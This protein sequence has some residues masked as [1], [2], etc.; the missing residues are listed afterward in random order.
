MR[1]NQA[2]LKF[3]GILAF[4]AACFFALL[5]WPMVS[6]I[7]QVQAEIVQAEAD[8]GLT[9]GRTDGL[10]QLAQRVDDLR[11]QAALNNKEIP[12]SA[13]MAAVL[14]QLSLQIERADL[15]GQG[16][17]TFDSEKRD[18]VIEVPVELTFSGRSPLVFSFV[19]QIEDMPRLVQ[20]DSLQ[21]ATDPQDPRQVNARVRVRTFFSPGPQVER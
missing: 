11:A 12:D 18:E 16:I 14:R 8:L 7:K 3:A 13:E 15:A 20:V 19:E 21:I 6:S 10:T 4:A 9:R 1:V 17:S 5:W 2:K